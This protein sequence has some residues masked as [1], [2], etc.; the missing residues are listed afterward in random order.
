VNGYAYH[1]WA[2][3]AAMKDIAGLKHF[4]NGTVGMFGGFGAVQGLVQVRIENFAN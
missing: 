4:E 1:G 3:N 2:Q